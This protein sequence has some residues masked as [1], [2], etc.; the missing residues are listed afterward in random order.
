MNRLHEEKH[1]Y[2][3]ANPM[4][5]KTPVKTRG[6]KNLK[7]P[8]MQQPSLLPDNILHQAP[9]GQKSPEAASTP[10]QKQTTLPQSG[11][12]PGTYLQTPP[13]TENSF[14]L[15]SMDVLTT[16]ST[17]SMEVEKSLSKVTFSN[18]AIRTAHDQTIA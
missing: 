17:T 12:R 11:L 5:G 15:E 2:M 8:S 9:K 7:P 10:R 4:Q 13:T 3:M 18:Q 14:D 16:M 6:C 1:L